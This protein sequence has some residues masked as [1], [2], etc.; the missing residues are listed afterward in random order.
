MMADMPERRSLPGGIQ[1]ERFA[2]VS[3]SQRLSGSD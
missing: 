1:V 2:D 3:E